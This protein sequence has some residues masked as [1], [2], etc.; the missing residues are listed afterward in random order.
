MNEGHQVKISFPQ[1]TPDV[2]GR[3]A[4]SL[5]TEIRRSVKDDG[6]PV[7]STVTRSDPTAMDFGATLV[8]VLGT[9]AI[10]ILARA[11]L[12][13]AKRTDNSDIEINGIRIT[14]LASKDVADVV[15]ALK[16]AGQE[17][18]SNGKK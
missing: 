15:T 3:L 5:A 18:S 4:D 7:E 16:A 13:W 8:L 17:P 6:K 12:E 9:P 2:A 11:V 14:N 10:I 1:K